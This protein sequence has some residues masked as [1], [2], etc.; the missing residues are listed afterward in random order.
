MSLQ[1]NAQAAIKTPCSKPLQQSLY[2]LREVDSIKQTTPIQRQ[3]VAT[4]EQEAAAVKIRNSIIFY[5]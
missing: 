2:N 1:H 4:V 3:P 5:L